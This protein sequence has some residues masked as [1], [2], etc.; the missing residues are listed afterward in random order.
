[1][2]TWELQASSIACD[3][4]PSIAKWDCFN[5]SLLFFSSASRRNDP[6]RLQD[7][8]EIPGPSSAEQE[9]K[10]WKEEGPKPSSCLQKLPSFISLRSPESPSSQGCKG[11]RDE[12]EPE[13]EP[14]RNHILCSELLRFSKKKSYSLLLSMDFG[15]IHVRCESPNQLR[16]G[17]QTGMAVR[18]PIWAQIL[19][20]VPKNCV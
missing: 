13:D 18:I 15:G 17:A 5:F 20:S 6:A 1:M 19:V 2:E 3:A 4:M 14:G 8:G 10:F 12:D 9:V 7:D 16:L 11:E